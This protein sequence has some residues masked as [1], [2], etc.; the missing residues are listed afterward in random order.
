MTSVSK[1]CTCLKTTAISCLLHEAISRLTR[2]KWK[3]K[4]QPGSLQTMW[5]FLWNTLKPTSFGST[6]VYEGSRM[7]VSV[8]NHITLHFVCD[9]KV[10]NSYQCSVWIIEYTSPPPLP[11]TNARLWRRPRTSAP[12]APLSLLP[13]QPAS[14]PPRCSLSR[15][16]K[17]TCNPKP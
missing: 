2:N 15:P 5:W 16:P 9:C 13:L 7:L 1:T 8:K 6:P 14:E 11:P 10:A 12:Q 4:T 3:L 17:A